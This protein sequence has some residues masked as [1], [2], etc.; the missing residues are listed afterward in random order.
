MIYVQQHVIY[1]LK[2]KMYT[3]LS[4]ILNENFQGIG[5]FLYII[6]KIRLCIGFFNLKEQ[7]HK[8]ISHFKKRMSSC[9]HSV[10]IV[11]KHRTNNVVNNFAF[12]ILVISSEIFPIEIENWRRKQ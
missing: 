10:T 9:T 3:S 1:K 11:W 6:F 4:W 8:I 12:F 7:K 2:F 5:N